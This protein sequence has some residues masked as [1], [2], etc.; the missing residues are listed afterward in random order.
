MILEVAR[1]ADVDAMRGVSARRVAEILKRYGLVTDRIHGRRVFRDS[2][3]QLKRIET[4]YGVDLNSSGKDN[5][6]MVRVRAY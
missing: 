4:R 6:R 1:S 2:L 5:V 3:A